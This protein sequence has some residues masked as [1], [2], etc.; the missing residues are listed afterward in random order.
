VKGCKKSYGAEGSMAQH[1]KFKHP[2]YK[3]EVEPS[4]EVKREMAS[5]QKEVEKGQF[6]KNERGDSS[7]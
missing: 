5:V 3:S 6:D 1:L 7:Y 2:E 4:S